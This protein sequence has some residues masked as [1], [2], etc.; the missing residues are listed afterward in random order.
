M[1]LLSII[2]PVFNEAGCIGD[3]LDSL[4]TDIETIVVDGGSTDSTVEIATAKAVRVLSSKIGR[5]RQMNTGASFASNEI[6]LFLHA[7]TTLPVSFVS[8]LQQFHLSDNVWGRFDIRIDDTSTIFRII[9]VMMNLRSRITGICTGDQAIFI[10]RS[11]FKQLGGFPTIALMEDIEISKQLKKISRPFCV[12]EPVVTSA[13]RWLDGG[14]PQTILLMWR[15]RLEYF[16]GV[17]PGY[18]IRQYYK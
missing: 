17:S 9:E 11:A 2:I 5:A 14:I 4:P 12:H 7:D 18:L 16:L 13:R 3:L 6:F 15:L 1:K 10:K 8:D